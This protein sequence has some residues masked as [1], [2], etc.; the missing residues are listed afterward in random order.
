MKISIVTVTYNAAKTIAGTLRSVASQNYPDIEHILIDGAS[1]DA[2]MSIVE[3]HRNSLSHVL[4]EPDRGIYD[5][6]N[7]G[8]ALCTG[9]VIGL[10]NGDDIYAYNTTITRI[11]SAFSDTTIDMVYGDAEF[12]RPQQP[13]VPIRRY[14][15]ANFSPARIAW[16]WMPAHPTLFLRRNIY[17]RFG[18]FRSEFRIAGDFEFVA[19]VFNNEKL[20][21]R[22]LPEVLVRMQLGGASTG[23]LRSTLQLN[24]EVILACR[25]NGIRTNWLKI[26]SKYPRK[27]Q[28]FW[29][30]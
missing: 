23:G 3:Q 6:M 16:G 13:N 12:V 8:I 9:D 4:S 10:L 19:R 15:S 2:T 11:A 7:K 29:R 30:K 28:E 27:L 14:S 1:S 25:Q 22:Y 20:N 5:A 24:Q 18:G 17:E 21:Y 26:L